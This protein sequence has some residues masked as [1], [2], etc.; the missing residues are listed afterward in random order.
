MDFGVSLPYLVPPQREQVLGCARR[1]DQS[2]R[3][4]YLAMGDSITFVN[5]DQIAMLAAAAAVTE[6]VRL[7]THV[8]V[9]PLAPP[10]VVAKQTATIDVLSEG[11][12]SLVF[13]AGGRLPDYEL[14]GEPVELRFR[15]LDKRV[16]EVRRLWTGVP[17]LEGAE[18]VGPQPFQTDGPPV[19]WGGISQKTMA[20]AAHWADGY[21]GFTLDANLEQISE[22]VAT[23]LRVWEAAR[24]P[25]PLLMT[26]FF[27]RLGEDAEARL[28]AMVAPYLGRLAP[29]FMVDRLTLHSPD[30][31]KRAIENVER[32]G[33]D[34]LTF[35]PT[36][37]DLA[38]LD[39]LDELLAAV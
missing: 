33:F 36:T 18:P 39:R 35:I 23:V 34:S 28:R 31:V 14:L 4:S 6:R 24:R 2:G 12:L 22:R 8:L 19:Y 20:R 17:P 15:E 25:R 30:A 5:G 11:R 3:F 32:A 10:A 29:Q 27:F 13:G 16:A 26:S 9:L 21:A 1:V 7:I 37:G 38:E